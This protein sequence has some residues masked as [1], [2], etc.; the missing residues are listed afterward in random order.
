MDS[1]M[2]G[3]EEFSNI[4]GTPAS[5]ARN[6]LA[7]EANKPAVSSMEEFSNI[8]GTPANRDRPVVEKPKEP[9]VGYL[10]DVGKG[11]F[12]GLERGAAALAGLPE[13]IGRGA[14][15]LKE[16]AAYYGL[17]GAEKMGYAD[18]GSADQYWK[19]NVK[20]ERDKKERESVLGLPTSGEAIEWAKKN[21]PGAD[22]EAK[23]KPGQYA[24]TIGEFVPAAATALIPG[25]GAE[26]IGSALARSAVAGVGSQALGDVA[27]LIDP[28][29][30]PYGK[31]AG[32]L[33]SPFA[34]EKAIGPTLGATLPQKLVGAVPASFR[35]G[36]GLQT[37]QE[38]A[39][40][41]IGVVG[42]RLQ[43]LGVAGGKTRADIQNILDAEDLAG[44]PRD[45]SSLRMIDLIPG[46]PD[47]VIKKLISEISLQNPET[48]NRVIKLINNHLERQADSPMWFGQMVTQPT[49]NR[50]LSSINSYLGANG[51]PLRQT[52]P[53][54]QEIADISRRMLNQKTENA[55]SNA[56][57]QSMDMWNNQLSDAL[58]N[59]YGKKYA[60][61]ALDELNTIRGSKG[62]T[63]WEL[64][65]KGTDV[66]GNDIL[67]P[68]SVIPLEFWDNFYK[69]VSKI[70]G[71]EITQDAQFQLKQA[72]ERG[73]DNHYRNQGTGNLWKEARETLT[74]GLDE[75]D[76]FQWGLGFFR[77][78]HFEPNAQRR[79]AFLK[80]FDNFTDQ[81]RA[82]A[83]AGLAHSIAETASQPQGRAALSRA[84]NDKKNQQVFEKI[85]NWTPPG[86]TPVNNFN[87]IKTSLD[88]AN[89]MN[90]RA[91][92][93]F[94]QN[95]NSWINWAKRNPIFQSALGGAGVGAGFE[96]ASKLFTELAILPKPI[97]LAGVL[98]GAVGKLR[99]VAQDRT[100]RNIMDVLESR[101]PERM[102]KVA[103]AIAHTK[104]YRT[105]WQTVK[106]LY[107]LTD[108]QTQDIYR[109]GYA[110]YVSTQPAMARPQRATGGRTMYAPG[111]APGGDGN[112]DTSQ[113]LTQ[114]IIPTDTPSR[115]L[116]ERGF[117]SK[118]AEALSGYPQDR[119][120]PVSKLAS[121]LMDKHDV[122][123][124]EL[125]YTGITTPESGRGK[126]QLADQYAK[127]GNI[128][129]KDL[130]AILESNQPKLMRQKYSGNDVHYPTSRTFGPSF[131]NYSED[132]YHYPEA[133]IP[134]THEL[135]PD[136]SKWTIQREPAPSSGVFPLNG[137]TTV[138][139]EFGQLV[140]KGRHL[141]NLSDEEIIDSISSEMVQLAQEKTREGLRYDDFH[142][143]DRKKIDLPLNKHGWSRSSEIETPEGTYKHVEEIQ[144]QRQQD[145]KKRGI[146]TDLYNPNIVQQ[147]KK[148]IFELKNSLSA[149]NSQ[150][151]NNRI[152]GLMQAEKNKIQNIQL[153][154]M[155]RPSGV[156]DVPYTN[157]D[158]AAARRYVK[159]LMSDAVSEGHAG[160]TLAPWHEQ[161]RRGGATIIDGLRVRPFNKDLFAIDWRSDDPDEQADPY[162]QIGLISRSGTTEEELANLHAAL[163]KRQTKMVLN[164]AIQNP[165]GG[166]ITSSD[167]DDPLM[168][169]DMGNG[170]VIDGHRQYYKE[171]LPKMFEK[172]AKRL[173]PAM[174]WNKIIKTT[175]QRKPTLTIRAQQYPRTLEGM[176]FTKKFIDKAKKEG[177]SSFKDGG[178]VENR[179]SRATG[180]RIPDIDRM[181]KSAKRYV[182]GGTKVYLEEPDDRIVNALRIAKGLI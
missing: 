46:A 127:M 136:V 162:F 161:A 171:F 40:E 67:V 143:N 142:F 165:Q 42:K 93:E 21:L 29:L 139:D 128:T 120:Y 34:F 75:R 181:F 8:S 36:I 72:I 51:Q 112:D 57:N 118:A 69:K 116:N 150:D 59:P 164:Y 125:R 35:K 132:V 55:L 89:T 80:N 102:M 126:V 7:G 115:K 54:V 90:Q 152:Q 83:S 74:G 138:Y 78:S 32:A 170:Q 166:E 39:L 156:P 158:E 86:G 56:Y 14:R 25:L 63:Q 131:K 104:E 144:P 163:G 119:P 110:A 44:I 10:S 84:L 60:V 175:T 95:Q 96:V 73:I 22:Y 87:T 33:V 103:D 30:E 105:A 106:K 167:P 5:I 111:G 98:G 1:N 149:T 45:Q 37:S 47:D 58:N 13:D 140:D 100:A 168:Y 137:M 52:V 114:P 88:M 53:D 31:L 76:A 177:F 124:D 85:L 130:S 182:D 134:K 160:L 155:K 43:D 4:S 17:K 77:K 169:T 48:E 151:E 68:K 26:T 62:K 3:M 79:Q 141:H 101:D 20:P 129:P 49:E 135:V 50:V 24:Q 123:P 146:I 109:K 159:E 65:D 178:E 61:Q 11:G 173:D 97:V 28:N 19:K 179:L 15:W 82:L 71:D 180:G 174:T 108:K 113:G 107:D 153:Q 145:A 154:N 92:I 38:Q 23:T 70:P 91:G 6:S 18:T 99:Q 16:E 147:I 27:G 64:F 176:H 172:E 148:N 121:L 2:K 9:E 66:N 94:L 117:Y 133:T 81:E 41:K 122:H 12:A 157:S